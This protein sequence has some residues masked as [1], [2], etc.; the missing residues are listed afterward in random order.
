MLAAPGGV[1]WN[2]SDLS[3]LNPN[4]NGMSSKFR[5]G[6]GQFL[7]DHEH[8]V[9]EDAVDQE[10]R[11]GDYTSKTVTVTVPLIVIAWGTR[12]SPI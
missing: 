10:S 2:S 12:T 5:G 6:D 8:Y 11:R 4:S 7:L 9:S 1:L 3:S